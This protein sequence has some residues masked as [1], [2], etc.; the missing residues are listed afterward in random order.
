MCGGKIGIEAAVHA[1]RS[2]FEK[3]VLSLQIPAMRSILWTDRWP[4]ITSV[5]FVHPLLPPWSIPTGPPRS[6]LLMV[7]SQEGTTQ[8]DPLAMPMYALATIP[9]IKK[10]EGDST[11]VWYADDA[12]AAGKITA[13]WDKLINSGPSFGYFP[14]A[15]KSW[16][17]T[18]HLFLRCFFCFCWHRC[19]CDSWRKTLS[20][21]SYRLTRLCQHMWSQKLKSGLRVWKLLL[22]LQG[23]N[24]MQLILLLLMD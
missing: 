4:S 1:V 17:V 11:Q 7:L 3:E 9:L 14:N 19:E 2:A 10:L 15:S 5:G 8:G 13:R 12:A 23:P 21:C 24:H 16:L 20:R 18:K 6:C 22:P